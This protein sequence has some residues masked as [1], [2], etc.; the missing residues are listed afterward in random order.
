MAMKSWK[1][2]T[3]ACVL[4]CVPH[5][6]STAAPEGCAEQ[7]IPACLYLTGGVQRVRQMWVMLSIPLK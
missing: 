3:F 7:S 5:D 1:T 6:R 2:W 4:V